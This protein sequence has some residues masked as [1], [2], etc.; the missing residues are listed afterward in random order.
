MKNIK[1]YIAGPMN[2]SGRMDANVREALEAASKLREASER[3]LPFIPHL[4]FFWSVAIPQQEEYWLALDKN[5][6]EECNCILQLPGYSLG[7][8][9]ELSYAKE[10]NIPV[11]KSINEIIIA[12]KPIV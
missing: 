3:F 10:K 6:L 1:I 8:N 5:W 4:Y 7:V 9:E 11:Y 12:Y 2:S